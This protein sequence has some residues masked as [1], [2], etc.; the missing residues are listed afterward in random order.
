M[1]SEIFHFVHYDEVTEFF[2]RLQLREKFDAENIK[3]HFC[4]T[5]ITVQNFKGATRYGGEL[6]F[7]CDQPECYESFWTPVDS[8]NI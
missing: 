2:D 3:C 8:E 6:I 4:H 7:V 5:V 1:S